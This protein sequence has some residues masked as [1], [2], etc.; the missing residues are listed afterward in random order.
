[1]CNKS[2]KVIAVLFSLILLVSARAENSFDIVYQEPLTQLQMVHAP[3]SGQQKPGVATLRN[4]A[5]EAYGKRFD[6][7]LEVNHTLLDAAQRGS[8]GSGVEVYRGDITGMPNS[9]V[10]LVVANDAPRG[11]L[12]DGNE[13]W[14]IEVGTSETTGKE[15]PFIFRLDDLQVTLG[16]LT[17]SHGR[18]ASS[19]GEFATAMLT[20]GSAVVAQGLGASSQIDFAVIADYEFTRDKGAG[21]DTA[22]ISRMNIVD[23][24][25]SAQLGVQL[26]VNRIDTYTTNNDPFGNQTASGELLDDLTD[27]RFATPSQNTNGLSHLFTGRNLDTSTVG[28]AYTGALCSRRYGAGLTQGTHSEVMDSL[29]A[30]HEIGHNFGAPHDGTSN[31]ACS[32][33]PQDFLMAPRLNGSDT[34]SA[35]SITQMQDDVNRA[36]CISA[37]PSTDVAI[38][39][40]SQSAAALLGDTATFTFEANSIGTETVNNA[41]VDVTVPS[42]ITLSSVSTTMGNC[43][44]GAGSV[45][46]AIGSIAAGSGATVTLTVMASTIGSADFGATVTADVD[47]NGSNNQ[48]TVRLTVD[49]AVDLVSTAA[50]LTQVSLNESTTILPGVENRSSISAT[51]VT[52]TVTPSAGISLDSASWSAGSCSIAA[53]IVTCQASSL[54]AQSNDSLQIALTAITEGSQSYTVTVDA[55]E[56]DRDIANNNVSGQISVN[57]VTIEEDGGAGSL[58]WLSVLLLFFAGWPNTRF[59][60]Y[61]RCRPSAR[62]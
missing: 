14:A 51:G 18:T 52:V 55:T 11:V 43:T 36:S 32:S 17:C 5:F 1:M 60:G 34:F 30:A 3:S 35:C 20:E 22:L 21:V 28:I 12:W 13:L 29:I 24:I 26:N 39:A 9:W 4:L 23:G 59:G 49:P 7:N 37:M 41:N 42:G 27:F 31:E 54:A 58:G 8:L 38:V 57:S 44:S 33:E 25:F 15:Q 46:C 53:N 48:A 62:P 2:T 10:R 56:S 40:G 61:V 19:A 45:S 50:A 47:D 6:I 16:A